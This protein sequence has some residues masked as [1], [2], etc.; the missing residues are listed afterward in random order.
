MSDESD[1]QELGASSEGSHD[2][3]EV[4]LEM[5]ELKGTPR[6]RRRVVKRIENPGRCWWCR[7]RRSTGEWITLVKRAWMGVLIT[8]NVIWW[9]V[10]VYQVA[11]YKLLPQ[12][13]NT[14]LVK[15]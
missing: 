10:D 13:D 2:M 4:E 8:A 3:G 6:A 12:Q 7:K 15:Y 9:L 14:C 11:N 5:D 1:D